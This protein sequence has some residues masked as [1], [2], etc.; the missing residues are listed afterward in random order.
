M[1]SEVELVAIAGHQLKSF[2]L[3][4]NA[5]DFIELM[6]FVLV[7]A[8]GAFGCDQSDEGSVNAGTC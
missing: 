1:E 8:W 2:L 7:V 6:K 4:R 5:C 3:L